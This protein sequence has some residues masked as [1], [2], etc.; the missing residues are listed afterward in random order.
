MSPTQEAC[1]EDVAEAPSQ[2]LGSRR[3]YTFTLL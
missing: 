2:M 3:L 1:A